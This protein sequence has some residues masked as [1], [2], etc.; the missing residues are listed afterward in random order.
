MGGAKCGIAAALACACLCSAAGCARVAE[1]PEAAH[2]LRIVT[3]FYPMYL[4]A[5]NVAQGVEGVSVHNMAAPEVGCLHDYQLLPGDLRALENTD[6]LVINGAGMEPFLDKVRAQHPE[7]PVIEASEGIALLADDGHEHEHEEEAEDHEE[8][9]HDDHE[10]VGHDDHEEVGHDAYAEVGGHDHEHSENP[11]VW[12][13]PRNAAAQVRTIARRL[14]ELDPPNAAQYAANAGAYAARL[15]ALSQRM[16]AEL[17]SLRE[18]ELY[19]FHEAFAYFA[20]A[21]D[22]HV[23]G[24]IEREP[25]TGPGTRDLI[26]I[27][28]QVRAK[29]IPALFVEPQYPGRVAEIIARESGAT[30]YT[31]DPVVTGPLTLT[32]YEEAMERN[33]Q[34]LLEALQ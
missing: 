17:S 14:G 19:T 18:R 30:V 8:A 21:F 29:E 10:E 2:G 25:G 28:D 23:A 31:L 27:V 11:H 12:V 24:V 5:A 6:V 4:F 33:L 1:P 7:L 3:S 22:F 16:H 13:D 9:D 20:Q 15:E 34:T 26:D 32:A